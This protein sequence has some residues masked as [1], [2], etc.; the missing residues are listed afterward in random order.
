MTC[1]LKFCVVTWMKDK[2]QVEHHGPRNSATRIGEG[3]YL[4]ASRRNIHC[5]EPPRKHRKELGMED[6]SRALRAPLQKLVDISVQRKTRLDTNYSD[7]S[8]A[9]GARVSGRL[10]DKIFFPPENQNCHPSPSAQ[11]ADFASQKTL[12]CRHDLSRL[13]KSN[14]C[15][16]GGKPTCHLPEF[17][18]KLRITRPDIGLGTSH[19][20]EVTD[21][22]PGESLCNLIQ[23]APAPFARFFC[24]SIIWFR[25]SSRLTVICHCG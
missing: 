16:D 21:C 15:K 23:R 12:I 20:A 19:T 13:R 8:S 25:I 17:I 18:H 11:S 6:Q 10:S 2:D 9:K 24:D 22:L 5:G 4:E 7:P 14:A 3:V 1:L